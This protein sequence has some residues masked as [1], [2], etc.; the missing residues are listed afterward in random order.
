MTPAAPPAWLKAAP[1]LFLV[2]WSSGFVV[3]KVG[4]AY[5][6]PLTFL[7]LRYACVLLILTPL[8]LALRPPTCPA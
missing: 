7:A 1:A 2:L 8:L 3:L 5:A 6:D 4:L